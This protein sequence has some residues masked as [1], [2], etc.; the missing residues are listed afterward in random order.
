MDKFLKIYTFER[1]NAKQIFE[2]FDKLYT[3]TPF[4]IKSH[5]FSPEYYNYKI[6]D[7]FQIWFE[8]DYKNQ[9]RI[10]LV[11]IKNFNSNIKSEFVC[12]ISFTLSQYDVN[13][14]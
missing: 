4:E 3:N 13:Y 8:T 12:S 10:D 2:S 14:H 6:K 5:T 7:G 1:F 11:P 9:Y